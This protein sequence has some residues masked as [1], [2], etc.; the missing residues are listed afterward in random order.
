VARAQGAPQ[1]VDKRGH[2]TSAAAAA[3]VF[4]G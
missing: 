2:P 3:L 1:L 4:N